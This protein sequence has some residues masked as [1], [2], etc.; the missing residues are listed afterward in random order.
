MLESR[1][2]LAAIPTPVGGEVGFDLRARRLEV[3]RRLLSRGVS[4]ATLRAVLP[5]W[6]GLIAE[7][8]TESAGVHGPIKRAG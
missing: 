8:D 7:L 4:A 1:P 5:E 2:G 6:D 3:V